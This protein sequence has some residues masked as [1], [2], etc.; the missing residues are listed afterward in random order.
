MI[1]NK[2]L[3]RLVT[4]KHIK[5]A[6]LPFSL[7]NPAL[8]IFPCPYC[9]ARVSY[10]SKRS[11]RR[12]VVRANGIDLPHFEV[13]RPTRR[14]GFR[15]Y[16][17]DD[18]ANYPGPVVMG[19][20]CC[21]DVLDNR[22]ALQNHTNIN[23]VP[24]GAQPENVEPGEEPW[25]NQIGAV[26]DPDVPP[27]PF[28]RPIQPGYRR[29]DI[30]IPIYYCH[31]FIPISAATGNCYAHQRLSLSGTF[32]M[33]T[34]TTE[35]HISIDDYQNTQPEASGTH[36]RKTTN[37][38]VGH[39]KRCKRINDVA[40]KLGLVHTG[41]LGFG[42]T[43]RLSIHVQLSLMFMLPNIMCIKEDG[44]QDM[45]LLGMAWF[46][47]YGVKQNVQARKLI[48]RITQNP[49]NYMVIVMS[50]LAVLLLPEAFGCVVIG[51][52]LFSSSNIHIP[53]FHKTIL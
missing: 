9:Q 6:N 12:H 8:I 7:N 51:T 17:N 20:P 52:P 31:L 48:I 1:T 4:P 34:I 23:H 5:Y 2:A 37:T 22:E 26:F 33:E 39:L 49:S 19:C 38:S 43:E 41:D 30:M 10:T 16:Q 25:N 21:I 50:P 11:V 53:S 28:P 46:D 15:S 18:V 35:N 42:L 3:L 44:Q 47:T 13:G 24:D 36:F 45:L 27:H 14:R 40:D 32:K 29:A